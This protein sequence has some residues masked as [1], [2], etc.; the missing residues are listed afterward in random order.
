MQIL[1]AL[2]ALG[3]LLRLYHLDYTS[4][5]LDEAYTI[6]FARPTLIQIW[7]LTTVNGECNPPLFHWIE[8]GMLFFGQSEF[9]IRIVP[10]LAGIATIPIFYL[11]GREFLGINVGIL[12]AALLALS[13][14]HIFYS[15]EGRAYTLVLL[16]VSLALFAYLVALRSDGLYM[17]ALFAVFSA[18]AF[19]THF[20]TL[21][22]IALLLLSALFMPRPDVSRTARMRGTGVALGVFCLLCLPMIPVVVWL[23]FV[24]TSVPPTWGSLGL[25]T[26]PAVASGFAGDNLLIVVISTVLLLVGLIELRRRDRAKFLFAA[27][28]LAIPLIISILLSTRMPMHPRY[29]IYLLPLYFIGISIGLLAAYAAAM[30]RFQKKQILAAGVA[31]LIL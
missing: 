18:L 7:Q 23:F 14:F 22:L 15:Q 2:I 11:I 6:H 26:I 29:L 28:L 27:G 20:Y 24:R 25:E 1:L 4:L 16:F 19:W 30:R 17:W 31:L 8:H 13:P 9:V 12:A 5:W 3:A 10:A 21:I